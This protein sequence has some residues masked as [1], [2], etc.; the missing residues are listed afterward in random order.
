MISITTLVWILVLWC[1]NY[2][3]GTIWFEVV[4]KHNRGEVWA[5]IDSVANTPSIPSV[6]IIAGNIMIVF[7]L[8]LLCWQIIM[9]VIKQF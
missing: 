3:L 6:K 9:V 7:W 5:A 4:N 1:L 2:M 8:P